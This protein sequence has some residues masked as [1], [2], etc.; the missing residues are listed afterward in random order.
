MYTNLYNDKAIEKRYEEEVMSVIDNET[1][2]Y[3]AHISDDFR[4]INWKSC[5][6]WLMLARFNTLCYII[7]VR[8][9]EG[10]WNPQ[11]LPEEIGELKTWRSYKL[12]FNRPGHTLT[13][14][15]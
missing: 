15:M 1:Q 9:L 8:Y 2:T 13:G 5:H 12:L 10:Y 11:T 4:D 3:D 6:P 7:D 14:R